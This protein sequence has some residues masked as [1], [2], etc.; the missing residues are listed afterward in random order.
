MKKNLGQRLHIAQTYSVLGS[1]SSQSC[2]VLLWLP[3]LEVPA[4][5]IFVLL[6]LFVRLTLR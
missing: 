5:G 6:P 1:S 2:A 3:S 4:D